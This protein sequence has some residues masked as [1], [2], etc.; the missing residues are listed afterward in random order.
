MFLLIIQLVSVGLVIQIIFSESL[1]STNLP[2]LATTLLF[3]VTSPF[4][5]P[6]IPQDAPRPPPACR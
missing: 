2:E 6:L 1:P 4:F 3:F 5:V